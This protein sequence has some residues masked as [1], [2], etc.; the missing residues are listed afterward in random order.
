[1]SLSARIQTIKDKLQT[2]KAKDPE[3]LVF[4]AGD[5]PWYN[6]IG[7]HYLLHP[8]LTE[9][10]IIQSETMI[11]LSLPEEYRAFLLQ[12]GNGGAGPAW[13]MNQLT[14]SHPD[15]EFLKEYPDFCTMEFPYYNSYAEGILDVIAKDFTHRGEFHDPFGGYLKLANY[16]HNMSAIL[17]VSGEQRGKMWLL[18]EGTSITPFYQNLPGRESGAGFLDWYENWLDEHLVEGAAK[19]Q[20]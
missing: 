6:I 15:E 17:V 2:L 19:S 1:M 8:M 12:V 16:G 20:F 7:H 4:G 3:L 18:D 13:G 9:A 11:G 14:N 10:E 5:N